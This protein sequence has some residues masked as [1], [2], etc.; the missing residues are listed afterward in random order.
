MGRYEE[1]TFSKFKI[2]KFEIMFDKMGWA[3]I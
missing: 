3:K 1:V 2:F